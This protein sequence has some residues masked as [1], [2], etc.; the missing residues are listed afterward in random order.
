MLRENGC[1]VDRGVA[2]AEGLQLVRQGAPCANTDS[3]NAIGVVQAR[4]MHLVADTARQCG[5]VRG[6][7]DAAEVV[8]RPSLMP[9]PGRCSTT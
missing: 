4:I 2:D 1:A 3:P 5:E 8:C 7:E 6:Y 9:L